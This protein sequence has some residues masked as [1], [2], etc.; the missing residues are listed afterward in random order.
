MTTERSALGLRA[1]YDFIFD[2]PYEN[3]EDQRETARLIL[4]L[5]KPYIF[6]PFSL[7]FYPGTEL[8]ER[9]KKDGKIFD[10]RSQVYEKISNEFYGKE[11]NYLKLVC[12]LLPRLPKFIGAVLISRPFVAFFSMRIFNVVYVKLYSFLLVLKKKFNIG[13]KSLYRNR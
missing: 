2:N 5:P 6:Q 13:V 9:A 3:R 10:E 4:Q 1:R 7:T 12:L 11:V 8:F